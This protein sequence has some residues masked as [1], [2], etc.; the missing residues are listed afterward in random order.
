MN[1]RG[2]EKTDG[3]EKFIAKAKEI[4]DVRELTP[5]LVHQFISKIIIHEPYRADKRRHQQIDIY[6]RGVGLV[7]VPNPDEME[8]LFQKSLTDN[9]QSET[10][11]KEKNPKNEKTAKKRKILS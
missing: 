10:K 8:K 9:G 1:R 5:E 4:T 3:L 7:H 2:K 11:T 6:Y